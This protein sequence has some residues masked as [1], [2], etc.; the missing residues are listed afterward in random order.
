MDENTSPAGTEQPSRVV[1]LTA[2]IIH[3]CA[4]TDRSD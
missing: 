2:Q 1:P 4:R 3:I